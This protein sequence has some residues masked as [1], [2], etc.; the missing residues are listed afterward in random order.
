[1]TYL[2]SIERLL[3]YALSIVICVVVLIHT[4]PL[5]P[6][7]DDDKFKTVFFIIII[8]LPITYMIQWLMEQIK[9]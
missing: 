5:I 1:M 3:G 6:D 9:K 4:F 8:S 2:T 7:I